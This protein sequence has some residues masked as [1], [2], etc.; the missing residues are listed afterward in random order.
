MPLPYQWQI[1]VEKWK[2]AARGLFG[3]E[4][5]PRLKC[6]PGAVLQVCVQD[7]GR[8][9]EQVGPQ[10]FARV[11]FRQLREI[12]RDLRFRVAPREIRI[13]LRETGLRQVPHDLGPS[14]RFR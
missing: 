14:E 4:Q 6:R 5:Q 3:G 11:A 13:G 12:V 9:R 8:V 1:R 2:N 7:V 10:E